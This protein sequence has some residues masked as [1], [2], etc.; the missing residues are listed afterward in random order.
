MNWL[1]AV[2]DVWECTA[3]YNAQPAASSFMPS[4]GTI[5]V[6]LLLLILALELWRA[7]VHVPQTDAA[8]SS[9]EALPPVA[10]ASAQELIAEG[11]DA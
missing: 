5:A 8:S 6:I 9:V 1:K 11:Y 7:F 4:V 2:F 3:D 10:P